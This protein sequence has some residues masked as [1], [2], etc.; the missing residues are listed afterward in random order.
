LAKGG[1]FI[2]GEEDIRVRI[3]ADLAEE[4]LSQTEDAV[5]DVVVELA[6]D[7]GEEGPE[8]T[9]LD[10]D[11]S[12]EKKE[13]DSTQETSSFHFREDSKLILLLASY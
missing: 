11:L 1:P 10:I 5:P 12:L 9:G 6:D 13:G 3:A 2:E 8:M 7:P 4:A